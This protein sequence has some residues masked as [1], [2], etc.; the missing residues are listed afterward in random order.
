MSNVYLF[1]VFWI[2]A[3]TSPLEV[4]VIFHFIVTQGIHLV[5][6]AV[7]EQAQFGQASL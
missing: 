7:V 5:R 1:I 6:I 4:V 2:F 3:A